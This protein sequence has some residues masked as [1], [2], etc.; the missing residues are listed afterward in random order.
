[1]AE[2]AEPLFKAGEI[3]VL[4]KALNSVER[5][6]T[7]VL[8]LA[9]PIRPEN[10]N[11]LDLAAD[12]LLRAEGVETTFVVSLADDALIGVL[13]TRSG[14]VEPVKW[15]ESLFPFPPEA[16]GAISYK[17]DDD[18]KTEAHFTIPLGL[19]GQCKDK[20]ALWALT[21][22]HVKDLFQDKVGATE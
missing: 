20:N 8:A 15:I 4:T 21:E 14:T 3:S 7:Y 10:A 1:M 17:D 12:T 16:E 2:E 22:T 6:N 9:G 18:P 5:V 19:L 13:K 11:G